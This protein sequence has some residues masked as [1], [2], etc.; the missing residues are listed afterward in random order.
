[1]L[2]TRWS[3]STPTIYACDIWLFNC[4]QSSFFWSDGEGRAWRNYIHLPIWLAYK[5]TNIPSNS[6]QPRVLPA[7]WAFKV[8]CSF[9]GNK[10]SSKNVGCTMALGVYYNTIAVAYFLLKTQQSQTPNTRCNTWFAL[11]LMWNGAVYCGSSGVIYQW[12]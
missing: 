3:S 7:F 2:W 9:W 5:R 10:P 4:E 12:D 11:R 1:M 6:Q 8:T